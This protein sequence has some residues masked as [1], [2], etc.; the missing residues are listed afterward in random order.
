MAASCKTRVMSPADSAPSAVANEP[1]SVYQ[2]KTSVLR[3]SVTTCERAACS[4]GRN[5]PTSWPLG[6]ITPIV[7]TSRSSQKLTRDAN[8]SPAA[9]MSIAPT[10]SIRRRPSRSA[11]V[12]ITSEIDGVA[13]QGQREQEPPCLR[14]GEPDANQV[15][16][17]HHRQ[18]PIG[19]QA[20]ESRGKEQPMASRDREGNASAHERRSQ[21][22]RHVAA[23]CNNISVIDAY[24][25]DAS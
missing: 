7:A 11:R 3:R 1:V 18:R 8:T 9:A 24:C 21:H 25:I 16:D 22:Q 4:I 2:A 13:K 15:E 5:G 14:C 23:T 10:T 17:Q 20:D 19:E 12:V 6:L